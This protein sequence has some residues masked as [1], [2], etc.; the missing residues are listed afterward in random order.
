MAT[1]T[2][3]L[4][5]SSSLVI[6]SACG[7]GSDITPG[8][9]GQEPDSGAAL[10]ASANMTALSSAAS[11]PDLT[12]TPDTPAEHDTTDHSATTPGSASVT[13][14]AVAASPTTAVT[15]PTPSNAAAKAAAEGIFSDQDAFRLV[16]QTS[17]GPR[18]EDIEQARKFGPESWIDQQMQLPATLLTETLRGLDTERWNEYVNAWW[19]QAIQAEDQLRQ[20]VAF[21]LSEILVVS[22]HDGLSSEQLGLAGYYD[23]LIRN[24]FGNYRDILGEITLNP[25]MGE[26]LSMKG[27]RKPDA[28]ENIQ[29]DENFARE[30][31]Q[32][33]SIGL[34][35]LNDDGTPTLDEGGVALPTYSQ[36]TIQNFARVFTGWHFANA[37]D[38][39]WPQNKDYLSAMTAWQD[40]HDTG[41]K[42]LLQ[43][44]QLPAGQTAE[45]DLNDALDNIFSHPNVGPFISKQLIQRL[46][47][48]NPSKEYVR[49]VAAVFNRNEN[50]ERGSLGSVIK[51]ILLHREARFGHLD[52]PESF[53]KVREPLL[54]V[55][56]LWRAFEPETIHHDFNYSWVNDELSQSPLNSSSVFNFF[57]PDFSQ[58]GEI[59]SRGLH[60]P[61]FQILDESSII[62]ITNRLLASSIWANNHIED[63]D[64]RQLAIDISEEVAMEADPYVLLEHLNL[65][66]L[67]GRMT[68]EL[69]TEILALMDER[70]YEGGE[71]QRVVEA[72]YLVASS[73]EAAIQK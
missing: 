31:L 27:N 22:A 38:F 28:S 36:E 6:L 65:L 26:Y 37:E 5:L 49:D 45:Q 53:G 3:I 68:E 70:D 17:F 29:P 69:K 34:Q 71:A 20:R 46:V 24:A 18:L 40:Y 47:T 66:L 43:S 4:F 54:R 16:E 58:P 30:L 13:S 67:G 1:K 60:S 56:H 44:V 39:R 7:A 73:P 51:A 12:Q 35:L 8:K 72:I 19:R 52:S 14:A 42:T 25:V 11:P 23:I 64:E 63:L 59:S 21:A 41:A 32:L 62:T 9:T 57:R 61:E 33:F 55:S 2:K 10:S 15:S 48:S 50:G